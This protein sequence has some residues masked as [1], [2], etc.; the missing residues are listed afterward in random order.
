MT[1]FSKVGPSAAN[2]ILSSSYFGDIIH[3]K[4]ILIFL[5]MLECFCKIDKSFSVGR[6]RVFYFAAAILFI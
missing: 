3:I 2:L 5:R 6:K 1:A 4:N